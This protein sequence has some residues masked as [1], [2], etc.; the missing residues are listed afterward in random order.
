MSANPKL[1]EAL[2][3]LAS[4]HY[5]LL[6]DGEVQITN[7]FTREIEQVTPSDLTEV[8][9]TEPEAPLPVET[10]VREVKRELL[11]VHSKSKQVILTPGTEQMLPE[12]ILLCD[13]PQKIQ[14]HNGGWFWANK[15]HKDAELELRRIKAEGYDMQILIAATKLY[16]KSDACC[17]AVSNYLM[18]GTWLTH[19]M[20]MEKALNTD[21]IQEHITQ[22]IDDKTEGKPTYYSR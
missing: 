18:R 9:K 20:Q 2:R 8:I 11:P 6:M 21:T 5:I 10:I 19:Y 17:E 22:T 15:F 7:K 4:E 16:Y 1:I 3:L 12:F 13:V 14:M